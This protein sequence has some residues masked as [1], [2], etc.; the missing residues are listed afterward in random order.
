MYKSIFFLFAIFAVT[1]AEITCN[2]TGENAAV[3]N[4][5]ADVILSLPDV[6]ADVKAAIQLLKEQSGA[7]KTQ[8]AA[9][10]ANVDANAKSAVDV[11]SS[12]LSNLKAN[13][14]AAAGEL[15]AD[16][17]AS[18]GS[19][20]DTLQNLVAEKRELL[21]SGLQSAAAKLEA[22]VAAA[23]AAAGKVEALKKNIISGLVNVT[24]KINETIAFKYTY[25]AKQINKN[26]ASLISSIKS[27]GLNEAFS[28]LAGKVEAGST[29]FLQAL[30]GLLSSGAA[31][32]FKYL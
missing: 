19:A 17:Q 10:L 3:V 12:F 26:V 5:A 16:V 29:T 11:L 7:L 15:S 22:A 9:S 20:V 25:L 4:V 13:V 24:K 30:S 28:E 27:G 2:S 14:Q 32:S 21:E 6:S 1:S 23:A 8:I 18:V 31:V